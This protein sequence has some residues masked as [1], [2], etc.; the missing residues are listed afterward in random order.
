MTRPPGT[1]VAGFSS[2]SSSAAG[3]EVLTVDCQ[4]ELAKFS[5]SSASAIRCRSHQPVGWSSV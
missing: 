1:I 4:G 3:G 2:R 5:S